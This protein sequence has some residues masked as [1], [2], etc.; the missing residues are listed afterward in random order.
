MVVENDQVDDASMDALSTE[1][2]DKIQAELTY[3]GQIKVVL[4]REQ[5]SV[6][7]AK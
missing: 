6:S 3:P 2:S 4:I 5:R 1:I 7:F